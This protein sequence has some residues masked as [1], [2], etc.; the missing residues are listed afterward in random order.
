M[1]T[2]PTA[3]HDARIVTRIT[4]RTNERE[5]DVAIAAGRNAPVLSTRTGLYAQFD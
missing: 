2:T 5:T 3:T 4:S 1:T